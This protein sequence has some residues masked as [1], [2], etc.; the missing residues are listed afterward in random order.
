MIGWAILHRALGIKKDIINPTYYELLDIKPESCTEALVDKQLKEQ[1]IK[2]RQNI[3]N[4]QFIPLILMFEK[5]KLERAAEIL[6]NPQ[7]RRKYDRYLRKK[8]HEKEFIERSKKVHQRLS[9]AFRNILDEMLNPDKTLD[10]SKR[11]ELEAKLRKLRLKPNKIKMIMERIPSPAKT[12]ASAGDDVIDY[13]AM[14]VGLIID[15]REVTPQIR[16]KIIVLAQKLNIPAAKAEEILTSKVKN[17]KAQLQY[18]EYSVSDTIE[19]VSPAGH[20]IAPYDE[21]DDASTAKSHLLNIGKIVVPVMSVFLF[22]FIVWYFQHRGGP[23]DSPSSQQIIQEPFVQIEDNAAPST[24]SQLEPEPN[25]NN[26]LSLGDKGVAAV[27]MPESNFASPIK[28]KEPN[29]SDSTPE[30]ASL[31][32]TPEQMRDVFYIGGQSE[33]V[34]TD[35]ASLMLLSYSRL[36]Q[37]HDGNIWPEDEIRSRLEMTSTEKQEWFIGKV[38]INTLGTISVQ[39]TAQSLEI[40]YKECSVEELMNQDDKEAVKELFARFDKIHLNKENPSRAETK[41]AARILYCLARMSDQ[42]IPKELADRIPNVRGCFAY[43][44]TKTLADVANT[45]EGV[46]HKLPFDKST[47]NEK[48]ACAGW[49]KRNIPTWG[50]YTGN[51]RLTSPV[52]GRISSSRFTGTRRSTRTRSGYGR[53]TSPPPPSPPAKP[54]VQDLSSGL[55]DTN[56]NNLAF[57]AVVKNY[58]MAIAEALGSNQKNLDI[59]VKKEQLVA[60]PVDYCDPYKISEELLTTSEQVYE[61]L[62]TFLEKDADEN[63]KT[64]ISR[65]EQRRW[66]RDSRCRTLLQKVFVY[67]EAIGELFY[68]LV[69]F[70]LKDPG[71]MERLKTI[72]N[73]HKENVQNEYDILYQLRES[74]YYQYA[75]LHQLVISSCAMPATQSQNNGRITR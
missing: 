70:R 63:M 21:D 27:S 39:T 33:G 62:R 36:L 24:L 20:E 60:Q 14:S 42:E 13:F 10:E 1:K 68:L 46:Q 16:Q 18:D 7:T 5:T 51:I 74:V 47:K 6:R 58:D 2:L 49:W 69:R 56:K 45:P 12:T 64:Q 65:I 30:T 44:I 4:Q 55:V 22:A 8:E 37:Y 26:S 35:V 23:E 31:L 73:E 34:L 11:P 43:L 28:V 17:T 54:T 19:I 40:D 75:L 25:E 57:L 53:I 15:G 41:R 61:N 48:N 38:K 50:N 29:E 66:G 67:N 72:Q 52:S 32:V 59:S 9:V 3:P 71:N